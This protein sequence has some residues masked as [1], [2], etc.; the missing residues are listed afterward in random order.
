MQFT[1]SK[2]AARRS[3]IFNL[4][5]QIA[6]QGHV[7]NWDLVDATAPYLGAYLVESENLDVLRELAESDDLWLNRISVM[8]TFAFLRSGIIEPTLRMADFHLDHEHD[9]MH[10]A[11]G[12]SRF[13]M[14]DL[15]RSS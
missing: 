6:R 10:K 5:L 2:E 11:V 14:I 13:A 8:L 1:K 9:L 15:H 3:E 4:Y 7:N 12:W